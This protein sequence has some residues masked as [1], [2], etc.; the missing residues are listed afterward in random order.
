MGYLY[1]HPVF[2]KIL[3]KD[4]I[5][6]PLQDCFCGDIDENKKPHHHYPYLVPGKS[7]D[8]HFDI[9]HLKFYTL[10]TSPPS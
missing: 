10:L 2:E 8:S 4:W 3:L 5:Y 7:A 6:T 1:S 9:F